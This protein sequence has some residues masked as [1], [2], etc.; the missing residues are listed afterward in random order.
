MK[1]LRWITAA[2][3]VGMAGCASIPAPLE[4]DY[5]ESFQPEQA[6]ERSLGARVRWGGTV[7]ETMP[8]AERTC[9]E[10]LA[11]ELDRSARPIDSDANHGRFLACRDEFIDPEIFTNGREVTAVGR[12]ES[13]RSGHVGEFV[14]EYP[15]LDAEAIYLWPERLETAWYGHA[16]YGWGYPYY[17]YPYYRYPF[18]YGRYV[19][20]PRT[21]APRSSGPVRSEGGGEEKK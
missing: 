6:N 19:H 9:I 10:I 17:W 13:F 16:G 21:I 14:Y 20:Y 4:G 15:V 12:L 1:Q 5:S 11:R 7:V 3:I 2:A 18:F 8:E